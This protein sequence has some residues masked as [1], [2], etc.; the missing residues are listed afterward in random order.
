M[1]TDDARQRAYWERDHRFRRYDHP[2]VETFANQRL[3]AIARLLDFDALGRALDVGCGD[4]FSTFY[5]RRRVGRVW[6]VDRSLWMLARHP[7]RPEGKLAAAHVAALPFRTASFDLVY[8]WEVLHH[9]EHPADAV[10][11]MARVSARWVLLAEPN[12]NNP[13]Q[14]LLALADREHRWVLRYSRRYLC[15]IAESAGLR[16]RAALSG[17]LIFPNRTPGPVAS[18]LAKLPYR[19]PLGISNIVLAERTA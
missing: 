15:G 17:G 2:V 10:R 4:G 12:R 11:E 18:L 6:A 3:D 5:M 16:V 14:A 19:S 13:A 1:T 9:V 7:M 8:A